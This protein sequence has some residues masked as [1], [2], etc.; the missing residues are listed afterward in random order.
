M[1]Q[2]TAGLECHCSAA[3]KKQNSFVQTAKE[4]VLNLEKLRD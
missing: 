2:S 3:D 1:G 4:N